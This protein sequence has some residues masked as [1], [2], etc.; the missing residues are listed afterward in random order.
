[1][2]VSAAVRPSLDAILATARQLGASDVHLKPGLPPVYRIRGDLRTVRESAPLAGDQLAAVAHALLDERQRG[3]LE[4]ERDVDLAYTDE[5]GG[6]YRVNVFFQRGTYGVAVRVIPNEIPPFDGLGL[7]DVVL[8]LAGEARGLVLVTGATGSGKSTTLAAM[9]DHINRTRAAHILTIEDP[10]EFVHRDLRSIVN[11]REL[12][13]DTTTFARA[14]RAALRQDPDV[15]LVGEMRDPETIETAL[16]AAETG[17]LVLSTLHTVDAAETINR[18]I[19]QFP[20]HHQPHVRLQVAAVLRG[21]ISQRLVP[22]ADGRGMIP[23]VEVMVV[24]QRIRELIESPARTREITDAIAGGRQPYG[25]VTFDLNLADHVRA[26][27]VTYDV[28]LAHASRPDDFA[29]QFR[30]FTGA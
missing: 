29:L 9:I 18:V 5:R 7:P 2:I 24:T 30:G 14:L 8:R 16:T 1:M 17:H 27:L 21:A 13:S 12:A 19:G 15:I 25:M 28:A 22:R 3:G 20:P 4:R 10:V 26:G 6:R 23:A 11:Q